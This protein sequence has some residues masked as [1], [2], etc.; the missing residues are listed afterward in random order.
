[1]IF[2][3]DYISSSLSLSLSLS[4]SPLVDKWNQTYPDYLGCTTGGL[5]DLKKDGVRWKGN[6]EYNAAYHRALVS[7]W[8][9][10]EMDDR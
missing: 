1:M 2:L 10:K 7:M 8:S 4:L 3:Y 5:W 6:D 9:T